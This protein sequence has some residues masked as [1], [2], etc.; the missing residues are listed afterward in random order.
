L[1]HGPFTPYGWILTNS[2]IT[3]TRDVRENAVELKQL[4]LLVVV[5]ALQ[6]WENGGIMV[7]HHKTRTLQPFDLMNQGIAAI[8]ISVVG[9]H[10]TLYTII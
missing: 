9:H 7:G 4:R 1:I 6:R 8:T 5:F 2:A 10:D 3:A